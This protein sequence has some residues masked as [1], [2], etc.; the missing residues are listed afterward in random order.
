MGSIFTNASSLFVVRLRSQCHACAV[1]SAAS[2]VCCSL[3]CRDVSDSSVVTF[4]P[5]LHKSATIGLATVGGTL[6]RWFLMISHLTAR[7][8]A[9][10]FTN[11]IAIGLR[12][13]VGRHG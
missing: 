2:F 13:F 11:L 4:N 12:K 3:V 7:I 1:L 8:V 9:P 10:Y 5:R 6:L